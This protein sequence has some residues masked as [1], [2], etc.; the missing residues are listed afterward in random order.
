MG[1][2]PNDVYVLT[3]NNQ[4]PVFLD[5]RSKL[6]EKGLDERTAEEAVKREAELSVTYFKLTLEQHENPVIELDGEGK[7]VIAV[8]GDTLQSAHFHLGHGV[9]DAL[10]GASEFANCL[11]DVS[12]G[13][14]SEKFKQFADDLQAKHA[15]AIFNT[16]AHLF[17]P[18]ETKYLLDEKFFIEANLRIDQFQHL[19]NNNPDKLDQPALIKIK[20]WMEQ[21]STRIANNS[22]EEKNEN[23]VLPLTALQNRCSELVTLAMMVQK[24]QKKEIKFKPQTR[25]VE[26]IDHDSRLGINKKI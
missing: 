19:L 18:I 11:S 17:I 4:D 8:I 10:L 6:I 13:F 20:S 22:A 1:I 14:D 2:D 5:K 21:V 24:N 25:S 26:S 16:I 3:T 12:Q 7:H 9:S 15:E 23:E